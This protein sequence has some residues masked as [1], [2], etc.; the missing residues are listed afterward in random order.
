L[1]PFFFLRMN[2][3]TPELPRTRGIYT[4]DRP[5]GAVL[6]AG[7]CKPATHPAP[8]LGR[9]LTQSPPARGINDWPRNAGTAKI[10]WGGKAQRG[11]LPPPWPRKIRADANPRGRTV[12]RRPPPTASPDSPQTSARQRTKGEW[13]RDHIGDG[14][15]LGTESNGDYQE[16][17]SF[18]GI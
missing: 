7:M 5:T 6:A 1:S 8:R 17:R 4:S 2:V 16:K 10:V 13:R 18:F 3:V 14:D 12:E 11:A 15:W 9:T